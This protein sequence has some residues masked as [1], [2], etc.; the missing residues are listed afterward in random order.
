MIKKGT[1][2]ISSQVHPYICCKIFTVQNFSCANARFKNASARCASQLWG[3][4]YRNN[5]SG[6]PY[7]VFE[8]S[9]ANLH[10]LICKSSTAVF[11]F[12]SA[13]AWTRCI[14]SNLC[15]F[16]AVRTSF[17]KFILVCTCFSGNL[18]SLNLLFNLNMH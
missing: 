18:F 5:F 9:K 15:L 3:A 4:D 7:R 6:T 8:K 1:V 12:L 10:T 16:S 13:A 17:N 2:P 11:I 14:T